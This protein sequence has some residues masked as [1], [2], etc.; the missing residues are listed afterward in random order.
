LAILREADAKSPTVLQPEKSSKEL[1]TVADSKRATLMLKCPDL[2]TFTL[3][4]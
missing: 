2:P 4:Y 3:L 1:A